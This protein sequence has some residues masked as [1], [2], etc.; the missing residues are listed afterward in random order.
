MNGTLYA[1]G[2]KDEIGSFLERDIAGALAAANLNDELLFHEPPDHNHEQELSPDDESEHPSKDAGTWKILVVDD[3]EDVHLVTHLVLENERFED[4]PLQILDAYSAE[5]GQRMLQEHPD[6]A[7]ILLDVVMETSSAGLDLVQSIRTEM[8]N[9]FVR[10]ILRTGQPGQA[11][12]RNVVVT[13]DINDYKTKTE[14]TSDRLFTIVVSSLRAYKTLKTIAAHTDELEHQ[15]R[16]RSKEL[17][18][19][20]QQLKHTEDLLCWQLQE[21]SLL[22]QMSKVLHRCHTEKETYRIVTETCKQ[23][24]PTDSGCLYML[25]AN[26]TNLHVADA[27]GDPPPP[28]QLVETCWDQNEGHIYPIEHPHLDALYLHIKSSSDEGY[29]CTLRNDNG[30]ILGVLY[31]SFTQEPPEAGDPRYRQQVETKRLVVSNLAEHYGLFLTNLRLRGEYSFRDPL[32]GLYTRKYL[33]ASLQREEHRLKRRN[34]PLGIM[35]FD[36]DHL[37][38]LNTTYGYEAGNMVLKEVGHCL[39]NNVRQEDIACRYAGGKFVLL[40][41]DASLENTHKRACELWQK[42]KHLD[43]TSQGQPISFTTS[44]GIAAFPNHGTE[45]P[46]VKTAAE[47]AIAQAKVQG[48][49]QLSQAKGAE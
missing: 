7:L 22:N 44:V 10:I 39:Q 31:I 41:P 43:L 35:I 14:L 38:I 18:T 37:K 36:I 27:W 1:T 40:L 45:I 19:Q 16:A 11:P 2:P 8:R 33:E 21:L 12:E 5:E 23:M 20:T 24:L 34:A 13:Y 49:D 47:D 42:L 32:T 28:A 9:Q 4:K 26:Q 29:I 3:E 17:E 30:E 6:T 25:D 46:Q 48:G 15:V